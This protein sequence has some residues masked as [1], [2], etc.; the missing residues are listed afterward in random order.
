MHSNDVIMGAMAFQFTSPTI[1]YSTVYLFRRR[2][3]KSS[4]LSA[5]GLCEG[6]SPVTAEFP[7]QR[8]SNAEN[9]F[10][11]WRHHGLLITWPRVV[12]RHQHATILTAS[13]LHDQLFN[14][15]HLF[16][17]GYVRGNVNIYIYIWFFKFQC[18]KLYHTLMPTHENSRE[19]CRDLFFTHNSKVIQETP[20]HT[21]QM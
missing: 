17:W 8:A 20:W 18:V 1:V 6:N 7:V 15:L 4:K 14:N 21:R 16:P 5:T 19:L 12:S 11:W 2:S 10:I 3:E 13:I 9:V